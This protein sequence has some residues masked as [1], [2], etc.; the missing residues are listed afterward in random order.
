MMVLRERERGGVGKGDE[1]TKISQLHT[2]IKDHAFMCD[3]ELAEGL[4]QATESRQQVP[5]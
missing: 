1:L 3:R 5:K 4:A 2:T